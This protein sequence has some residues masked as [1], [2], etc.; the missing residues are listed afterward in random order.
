MNVSA[1]L[2]GA[3]NR[4]KSI[5]S[6]TLSFVDANGN[7][8]SATVFKSYAFTNR[9][10]QRETGYEQHYDDLYVMATPADVETWGLTPMSSEVSL[11]GVAYMVGNNI[12]KTPVH[13]QIWLRIKN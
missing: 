1:A 2:T 13:W 11:D 8:Q 4:L 10:E 5:N 7:T 6:G 3:L 9:R 12:V